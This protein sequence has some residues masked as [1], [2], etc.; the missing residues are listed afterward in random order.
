MVMPEIDPIRTCCNTVRQI[1]ARIGCGA[2][3]GTAEQNC[4]NKN[5]YYNNTKNNNNN[6]NGVSEDCDTIKGGIRNFNTCTIR[7]YQQRSN[8]IISVYTTSTVKHTG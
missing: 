5:D 1:L 2:L 8:S 6:D 3:P 4:N 7:V